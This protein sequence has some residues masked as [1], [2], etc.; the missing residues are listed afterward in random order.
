MIRANRG[1]ARGVADYLADALGLPPA[2]GTLAALPSG[3]PSTAS[4]QLRRCLE[5]G[6]AFHISDL[7]RDERLVIEES[8]RSPDSPIRVIVAT[9]TLAQGVNMPAE[10]VV[11]PEVH[12]RISRDEFQQYS[13]ASYKNIAGRA[14]RLGLTERGRAIVLAYGRADADHIWNHYVNGEPE[15]IHSTL[16]DPN[17]DMYTLV[18]RVIALVSQEIRFDGGLTQDDVVAVW[19]EQSGGPPASPGRWR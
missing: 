1:A 14:G 12:R 17:A 7:D 4:A 6:V 13:V 11:L 10:T 2:A 15:G 16:L 8:F 19:T 9:T 18:L 3:D 5:G